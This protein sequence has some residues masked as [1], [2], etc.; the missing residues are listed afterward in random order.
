MK[1]TMWVLVMQSMPAI[2]IALFGG[3]V[4]LFTR[5]G[6]RFTLKIFIG[7]TLAAAFVG[8]LLNLIMLEAGASETSRVIAV[9]LGGYCARDV[10]DALSKRFLSKFKEDD[11][12]D[13][14]PTMA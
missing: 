14:T 11:D 4:S 13:D 2:V 3:F 6:K 7:G 5:P 12:D 8:L 1:D 9:S 10:L